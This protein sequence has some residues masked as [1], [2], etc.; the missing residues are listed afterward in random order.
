MKVK[1]QTCDG[2]G[3]V[4]VEKGKWETCPSCFGTGKVSQ[5]SIGGQDWLD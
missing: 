1:C 5:F 4:E 3:R 2:E